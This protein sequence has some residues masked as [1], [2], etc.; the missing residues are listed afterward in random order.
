LPP[1]LAD[2]LATMV[3]RPGFRAALARE[4]AAPQVSDLTVA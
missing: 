1:R 3:A 2:W 4:A